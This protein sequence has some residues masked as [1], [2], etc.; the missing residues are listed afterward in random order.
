MKI[1]IKNN[2]MIC[3]QCVLLNEKGEVLGVS[4]KTDHSDMGLCGGKMDPEDNGTPMVTIIREAKEETGLDIKNLKLI[5]SGIYR[6]SLQYTYL[7][8]WDGEIN[9]TE[10]HVVKWSTFE[11]LGRGSFGDYNLMIAEVLQKMQ[12]KFAS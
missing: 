11:E 3:V 2:Y 9:T 1:Y 5:H 10:P 4:R 6:G 12:V 7:A 8:D